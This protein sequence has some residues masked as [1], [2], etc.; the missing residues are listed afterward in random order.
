ML[1]RRR[2]DRRPA[3]VH[4]ADADARAVHVPRARCA[5]AARLRA[6]AAARLRRALRP[7]P[8]Q[9]LVPVRV[10]QLA[11]GASRTSSSSRGSTGSSAA[12]RT[13]RGRRR[14]GR[15]RSRRSRSSSRGAGCAGRSGRPRPRRVAG[16]CRSA[17]RGRPCRP[18]RV[19]ARVGTSAGSLAEGPRCALGAARAR[20]RSPASFGLVVLRAE[21]TPAPNLNDSAFHLQ[22][23]RWADGQIGEGRVPLD[24]WY[25]VPLARLV[26]LPSLPEP[27]AHAHGATRRA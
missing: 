23:V 24:G 6:P 20:R 15:S 10:L 25:P 19:R 9:P 27:P 13:T 2:G 3:R 7:L 14:S 18:T 1:D 12:S 5:R 16:D 4:V 8:P 17:C 22:M 21:T 26:L 11:M